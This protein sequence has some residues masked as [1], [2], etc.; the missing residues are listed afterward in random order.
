MKFKTL[1]P[2]GRR[3]LNI[4]MHSSSVFK[5]YEIYLS[6]ARRTPVHFSPTGGG[7]PK[8]ARRGGVRR[9]ET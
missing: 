3:V 9:R 2:Y 8:M 7:V 1:R 4:V 5:A 6:D